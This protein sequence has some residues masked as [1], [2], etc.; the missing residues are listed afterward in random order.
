MYFL[1]IMFGNNSRNIFFSYPAHL[2]R[3]LLPEQQLISDDTDFPRVAIILCFFVSQTGSLY[4]FGLGYPD[5]GESTFFEIRQTLY[6]SIGPIHP[7]ISAYILERFLVL[8][9]S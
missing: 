7:Y 8:F 3:L 4:Q 9:N 1:A 6:R 2:A 5:T